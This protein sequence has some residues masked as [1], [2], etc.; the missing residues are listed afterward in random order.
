MKNHFKSFWSKVDKSGDCWEWTACKDKRG[1]GRFNQPKAF[2]TTLAHRIA[3]MISIGPVPPEICVCHH[4]DNPSC[5][6]PDHLFLGTHRDNMIDAMVK[7]RLAPL[8]TLRGIDNPK[9]KLTE[10]QVL[11]IK[12][13]TV[14]LR[15]LAKEFGVGSSTVHRIRSGQSWKH[16]I[17]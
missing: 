3:Y 1:Y 9:N 14:P 17:P 7:K 12:Q 4:C 16:I 11:I 8:Q 5:V 2:K 10:N 6:N 15:I 13:S